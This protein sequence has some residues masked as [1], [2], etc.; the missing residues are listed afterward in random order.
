M[1]WSPDGSY[2]ICPGAMNNRGPTANI[3]IRK[4]WSYNRDLVGFR[5]AVTCVVLIYLFKANFNF[6]ILAF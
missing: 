3:V 6:F 2:I 4:N 1:D 5:K